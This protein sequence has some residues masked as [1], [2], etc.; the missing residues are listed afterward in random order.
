VSVVAAFVKHYGGGVWTSDMTKAT[1]KDVIPADHANYWKTQYG[2]NFY[3][4]Q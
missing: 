4:M 1:V 2:L 3:P